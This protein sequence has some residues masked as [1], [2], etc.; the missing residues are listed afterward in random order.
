M[1]RKYLYWNEAF[2]IPIDDN[3]TEG[4]NYFEVNI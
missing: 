3:E 2:Y 1:A 4:F